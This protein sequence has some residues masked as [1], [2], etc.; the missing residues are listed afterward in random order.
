MDWDEQL[1]ALL[2]DLEHQAQALYD[3]DRASELADRS[4]SEY[5]AVTLVSR[6]M[7]SV[8]DDVTLDLAGVGPISGRATSGRRRT[9]A[10]CTVPPQDWVV[11]LA[12]VRGVE[13]ASARSVPEV[14]WSPVSRLGLGSAL[15]QTRRHRCGVPAARGRRHR[16]RRPAHPGRG[17]LRRGWWPARA[18][19]RWSRLRRLRGSR[20]GETE[21]RSRGAAWRP[22]GE[23]SVAAS[24]RVHVERRALVGARAGSPG[25]PLLPFLLLVV[26]GV[27]RL[28]DV[29]L[30]DGPRVE[31]AQVEVGVLGA[32]LL[33]QLVARL[34]GEA[35]APGVPSGRPG[36]RSRG[37]CRGRRRGPRRTRSPPAPAD[38]LRTWVR[39]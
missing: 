24:R 33:A 27:H 36:G 39:T 14:A 35:R 11:R 38:R 19:R 1:F 26:S 8:D 3:A 23:D 25:L 9:G 30:D 5:A 12:A 29:L 17:R 20:A 22:R 13:G 21:R 34:V 15:R 28:H 7:A 37:A 31:V 10:W 6:L 2:D 16:P 4:R 18:G 32:E